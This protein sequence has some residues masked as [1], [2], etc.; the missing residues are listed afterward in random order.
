MTANCMMATLE[1]KGKPD[2]LVAD[3]HLKKTESQRINK[4][5]RK[6]CK[7]YHDATNEKYHQSND[8]FTD[9]AKRALI[10]LLK[11]NDINCLTSVWTGLDP[12][13]MNF[14]Q[15]DFNMT[16]A[17]KHRTIVVNLFNKVFGYTEDYG[18]PDDCNVIGMLKA[19]TQQFVL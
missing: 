4:K 10:K 9:C 16:A 15:C 6:I 1:L 11:D 19:R 2:M 3:L 12:K 14:S 17:V 18:C 5:G 13:S 7:N 8:S